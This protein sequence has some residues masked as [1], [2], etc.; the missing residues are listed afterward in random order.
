MSA[1]TL[2]SKSESKEMITQA[3]RMFLVAAF[4]SFTLSIWLW[5]SGQKEQG[6]FV[7]LWVPSIISLGVFFQNMRARIERTLK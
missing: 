6:L 3:D 2:E 4:L 7:G 1:I 5:F